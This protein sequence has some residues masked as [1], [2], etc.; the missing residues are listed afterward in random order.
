M[1]SESMIF[2]ARRY[3]LDPGTRIDTI[4]MGPGGYGRLKIIITLEVAD[5]A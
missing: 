3:V 5:G 4:H 1:R 2:F